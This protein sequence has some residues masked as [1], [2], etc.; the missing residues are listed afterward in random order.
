MSLIPTTSIAKLTSLKGREQ[1]I[2]V[3]WGVTRWLALALTLFTA[4]ALVDWRIDQ[5]QDTP[6]WVRISLT[7]FQLAVLSI[8]ALYWIL[9]PIVRGPSLIRLARRVEEHFPEYDHRLIT[10]I[11]LTKRGAR[12]DGMSPQLI[13]MLTKE[14]EQISS[15]HNLVKLADT[16]RLKWCLALLAWPL[17]VLA[18][19][20]MFFKPE[21]LSALFQ[22]QLLANVELPRDIRLAAATKK[23]PWPAGDEVV[24]RY[25]VTSKSGK[26]SKEMKGTVIYTSED[27]DHSDEC[28]LIWDDQTDFA[29]ERAIFKAKVPHSSK[30]FKFRARLGDGRTSKEEQ[31]VFEPRPQIT[32]EQVWVQSPAY[33][34][35]RP[36]QELAGKNIIAFD[37]SRAKVRI[38]VQKPI[39]EA[40][41]ILYQLDDKGAE[42]E[43]DSRE[44]EIKPPVGANE[45]LHDYVSYPAESDYF[46]LRLSRFAPR[47]VAYRV[48]VKDKFRFDSVDN[49]R[50][51]IKVNQPEAP[52]V[53]LMD[54]R[55]AVPG[56]EI[57]KEDLFLSGLPLRIGFPIPI[58][59]FFRSGIGAREKQRD[60]T[61]L[62]SYPA[63]LVYRINDEPNWTRLPLDEIPETAETGEYDL[64]KASFENIEYQ[65]AK[66]KNRVEFHAKPAPKKTKDGDDPGES[67]PPSRLEG[68]GFFDFETANLKKKAMTGELVP[69][70]VND[71][72]TFYVEV[73]DRDPAP[74]REPGQ[75]LPRTKT[76]ATEEQVIEALQRTLKSEEEIA[77]LEKRQK[78]VF[79][80]AKP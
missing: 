32:I 19:L 29:N 12:T 17:G 9:Y 69:L 50:G 33:I 71:R 11:Q 78:S 70:E 28:E 10:S 16:R 22:R 74:G 24:V 2:N 26:L 4:A 44:M 58:H 43:V 67:K 55:W 66:F 6:D 15:K 38:S 68:G 37:G 31:V 27:N 48:A 79:T 49:P 8:A 72:I 65:K 77:A 20:L 5:F 51:T 40:K 59:Y 18:F 75:S 60:R 45:G 14:S 3:M 7:L 54:E 73:F 36:V 47:L 21:L 80:P 53:K 39:T 13:E 23:N 52:F 64:Q 57:N 34:P 42:V 46:D 62:L 25:D 76:I 63:Y 56:A 41:L 1:I 61:G 35:E 30:N